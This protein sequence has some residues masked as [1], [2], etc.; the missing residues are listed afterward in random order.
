MNMNTYFSEIYV[1]NL[2]AIYKSSLKEKELS[3]GF[4]SLK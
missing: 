4:V 1:S 3:Q 2:R